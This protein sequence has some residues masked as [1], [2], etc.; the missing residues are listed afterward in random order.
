MGHGVWDVDLR[1]DGGLLSLREREWGVDVEAET[2][3]HGDVVPYLLEVVGVVLQLREERE[4][5]AHDGSCAASSLV[6]VFDGEGVVDH[7][8]YVAPVFGHWQ[9][10]SGGIVIHQYKCKPRK[11][12][13]VCKNT[14]KGL[15]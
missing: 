7:L 9:S 1:G 2:G 6:T 12:R 8:L 5:D 13:C 3:H 14:Q 4:Y 15:I 11:K 10:L